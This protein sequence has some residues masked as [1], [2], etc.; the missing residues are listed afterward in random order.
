MKFWEQYI[1]CD[2]EGQI[3]VVVADDRSRIALACR[4]CKTLWEF[5]APFFKNIPVRIPEEWKSGKDPADSPVKS[6]LNRVS[7]SLANPRTRRK[8]LGKGKL[9]SVPVDGPRSFEN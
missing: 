2:D 5:D 4:T 3:V 8:S 9:P 1:H 6:P 7:R